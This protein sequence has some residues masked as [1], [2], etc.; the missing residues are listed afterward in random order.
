VRSGKERRNS[1]LR[2]MK[3]ALELL[4][5]IDESLFSTFTRKK[6][7]LSVWLLQQAEKTAKK[8]YMSPKGPKAPNPYL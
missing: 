4:D 3:D 7:L 2:R 5:L 6:L 1:G 8:E